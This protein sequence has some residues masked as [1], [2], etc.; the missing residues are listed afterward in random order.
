MLA[1]MLEHGFVNNRKLFREFADPD[2]V[3]KSLGGLMA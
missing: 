2:E 1:E 3:G